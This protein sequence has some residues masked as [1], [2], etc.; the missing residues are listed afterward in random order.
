MRMI[1]QLLPHIQAKADPTLLDVD[2]NFALDYAV[3]PRIKDLLLRYMADCGE[4]SCSHNV[5]YK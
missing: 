4:S 2:G 3:N 5:K 1:L